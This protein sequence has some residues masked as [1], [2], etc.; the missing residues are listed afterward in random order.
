M[1][2]YIHPDQDTFSIR[3]SKAKFK[4]CQLLIVVHSALEAFHQRQS[5]RETWIHDFV[6]YRQNPIKDNKIQNVSVIFLV[7]NQNGLG[8]FTLKRR[9]LEESAKFDD[10]LQAAMVDHYNNLT[11]KSVFT[12]KFFLN[13]S[14]FDAD[15]VPYYLMKVDNDVYLNVPQLVRLLEDKKLTRSP[16]FLVG[17]RYITLTPP[18]TTPLTPSKLLVHTHTPL[19]P[20]TLVH[21]PTPTSHTLRTHPHP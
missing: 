4:G 20:T 19:H 18:H 1:P 2:H 5:V 11:L 9:L 12:L 8:N 3:P 7:G 6:K 15:T 14:N 10:I 16:M 13:T 17:H 21:P